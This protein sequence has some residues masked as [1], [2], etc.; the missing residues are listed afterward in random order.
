MYII[1]VVVVVVNDDDDDDVAVVVVYSP[2]LIFRDSVHNV[3]VTDF[4]S[5]FYYFC[6]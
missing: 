1:V 6:V 3:V 4:L 2:D 5:H